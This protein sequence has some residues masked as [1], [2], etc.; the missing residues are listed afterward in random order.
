MK[1]FNLISWIAAAPLWAAAFTIGA[2][3][4]NVI[5]EVETLSQ[6]S[7]QDLLPQSG[8][9][10]PRPDPN[11]A[12]TAF[13]IWYAFHDGT[14]DAF[15]EGA[16]ASEALSE[17]ATE[18]LVQ[19]LLDRYRDAGKVS[20]IANPPW[21]IGIENVH[22]PSQ[23]V[24][25]E[26][27][28]DPVRH[29]Y[30]SYL[31]KVVPSDDAFVGND[32][33]KRVEV[34][35]ADGKF[36]GPFVIDV[37][38]SDVLDAGVRANDERDVWMIHRTE[39]KLSSGSATTEP[40]RT[41][42][43]YIGSVRR[44]EGVPGILGAEGQ[45]CAT[46]SS[47]TYCYRLST[48]HGDFTRTGFPLLRIRITNGI[49]GS[50]SGSWYD[51]ARAGEGFLIDVGE[52]NPPLMS[53]SWYTFAPDGSGRQVWLVGSAPIAYNAAEIPLVE[54]VGGR[55]AS[56]E[57]PTRVVRNIWGTL[58]VG[59]ASCQQGRVLYTPSNA[60]YPQGDYFIRRLTPKTR[61]LTET[62]SDFSLAAGDPHLRWPY[63]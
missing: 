15:D 46:F 48:Q 36:L 1:P 49:D 41:H 54:A 33:P 21:G 34:F 31:A 53:L 3:E 38:G 14:I 61:G 18:R 12:P 19:P 58:R 13:P 16:L 17:L 57:N 45:G 29:R 4:R 56:L 63:F 32:D 47:P 28:L 37:F 9:P 39:T 6:P 11:R 50:Y 52:G 51:P 40:I 55:F 25:R 62:C 5:V 2:A 24:A 60:A 8:Q 27:L 35:D 30:F 44:P 7:F 10:T 43:G 59:F 22:D 42:G 23:P 26:Q 20:F